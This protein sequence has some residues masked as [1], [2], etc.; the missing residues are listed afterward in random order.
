MIGRMFYAI[1]QGFKNIGRNRLFS[2]ASVGTITACLFMFGIFYCIVAN[3]QYMVHAA[4]SNVGVTV[5]FDETVTEDKMLEIQRLID[6]RE[7]VSSTNYISADD[8]WENFKQD[9][10]AD[11]D[12]GILAGLDQ[13]NP[14]VDC[15]S[16]QVYLADTS[17]QAE[18]ISYIESLE[19]V[20]EVNASDIIAESFTNFSR[21]IGYVSLGIILILVFVAIF[22]ISNTVMIGIAV[23][24]EEIA[25]MK[26]IGATDLFVRGPFIVEGMT[27]GLIGSVIPVAILRALYPMVVDFVLEHFSIL[28]RIL[29]FMNVNDVFNI[30]IPISLAI[31]LGIGFIGSY[32][33]L[34]K[35]VRV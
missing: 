2:L 33:T 1:R 27:I 16:V 17:R 22:L 9:Y 7:E 32:M 4:E 14:L 5:F 28:N 18:L 31:G 25:I 11:G 26:Y 10:F 30:L 29:T 13:D 23:R 35:H 8:A 3:F 34:R 12:E 6:A 20:S 19:G 21:L 15:A 24:K